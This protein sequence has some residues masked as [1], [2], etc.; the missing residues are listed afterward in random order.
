MYGGG[1]SFLNKV[2]YVLR[3]FLDTPALLIWFVGVQF[4]IF[5]HTE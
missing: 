5:M 3:N 4:I 1:T 2:S